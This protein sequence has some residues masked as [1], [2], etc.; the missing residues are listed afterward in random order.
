MKKGS[1][2]IDMGRRTNESWSRLTRHSY[3]PGTTVSLRVYWQVCVFSKCIDTVDLGVLVSHTV[4]TVVSCEYVRNTGRCS[5]EG[6][7][8]V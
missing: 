4:W 7:Q 3:S 5:V 1:H 8:C 2:S 6:N